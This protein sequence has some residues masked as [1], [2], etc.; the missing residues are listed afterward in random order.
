MAPLQEHEVKCVLL[1]SNKC[2]VAGP[3]CAAQNDAKKQQN[4]SRCEAACG[5]SS[6]AMFSEDVCVCDCRLQGMKRACT[7]VNCRR[8]SSSSHCCMV[9]VVGEPVGVVT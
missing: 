8:D 9:C 4:G 6:A 2:A 5:V 7:A 3:F 1:M